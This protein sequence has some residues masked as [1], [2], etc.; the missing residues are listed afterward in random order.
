M[1]STRKLL[2]VVSPSNRRLASVPTA[3]GG[4]ERS[5]TVSVAKG[6]AAPLHAATAIRAATASVD[7]LAFPRSP[8][9]A[10]NSA[11]DAAARAVSN[12]TSDAN[13]LLPH[14]DRV[15]SAVSPGRLL[16]VIAP[17]HHSDPFDRLLVAQAAAQGWRIATR[18][19]WISAYDV[20]VLAC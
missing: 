19:L 17:W 13:R 20:Q 8:T 5:V 4:S 10:A 1:A 12:G 9:V 16:N 11:T 14:A 15:L 7:A 6:G 2:R 18:D 3:T